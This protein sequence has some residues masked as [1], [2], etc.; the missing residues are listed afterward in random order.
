MARK[1]RLKLTKAVRT[2][3]PLIQGGVSKGLSSRAISDTLKTTFGKSIR[4]STLLALISGYKDIK[5]VGAQLK[6][7]PRLS[8]PNPLRLPSAIT[9]IR[10]KYSFIVRVI[11]NI[12]GTLERAT[13]MVTVATN[14][15][16]TRLQL[17]VAALKALADNPEKYP[18]IDGVPTLLSGMQAGEEGTLS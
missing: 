14:T 6:F 2:M 12:E 9:T 4:R 5:T 1:P 15:L 8:R 3:L 18:I 17:E 7:L 16:M 10:S 11:G 13:Q